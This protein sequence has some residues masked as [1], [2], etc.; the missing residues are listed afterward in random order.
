MRTLAH[1]PVNQLD[2]GVEEAT[3]SKYMLP[4]LFLSEILSAEQPRA[5]GPPMR[6]PRVRK[7]LDGDLRQ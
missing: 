4:P 6:V 5:W 7:K 1:P 3:G 2:G